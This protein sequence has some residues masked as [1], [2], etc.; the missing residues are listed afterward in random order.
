MLLFDIAPQEG[1]FV[2]VANVKIRLYGEL[3]VAESIAIDIEN[4]KLRDRDA[5]N[6]EY[7]LYQLAA[8]LSVR[9]G[10]GSVDG[11]QNQLSRSRPLLDTLWKV[12]KGESDSKMLEVTE[13]KEPSEED[14]IPLATGTEYTL[15]S[16]ITSQTKQDLLS[17]S[18]VVVA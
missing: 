18:L 6:T 12:F 8:W 2:T 15:N 9:L 5:S 4:Q 16:P 14:T 11:Y 17:K 7:V 3:T 13:G 1:K 10:S